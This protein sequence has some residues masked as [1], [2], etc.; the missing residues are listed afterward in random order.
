MGE[1]GKGSLEDIE[2]GRGRRPSIGVRLRWVNGQYVDSLLSIYLAGWITPPLSLSCAAV[3]SYKMSF[4]RTS[5]LNS[6]CKDQ[7]SSM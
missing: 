3:S 1:R 2:V 4:S 6:S 7:P 5:L